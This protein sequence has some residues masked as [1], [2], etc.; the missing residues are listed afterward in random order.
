MDLEELIDKDNI[1]IKRIIIEKLDFNTII[2]NNINPYEYDENKKYKKEEYPFIYKLSNDSLNNL[3]YCY[4][5][6]KD[7]IILNNDDKFVRYV[8]EEYEFGKLK[9]VKQIGNLNVINSG[10]GINYIR[11][12]L[13]NNFN[14]LFRYF[15]KIKI[16]NKQGDL[17]RD[18][19][20]LRL[21]IIKL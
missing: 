12:K 3:D 21:L 8:R 6:F 15:K 18:I 7:E 13:G 10:G 14:D 5:Y 1:K 4:D 16:Y 19:Y 17:I 2:S 11:S 9:L 20:L